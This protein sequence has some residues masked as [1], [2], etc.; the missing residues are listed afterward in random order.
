MRNKLQAGVLVAMGLLLISVP[1]F[2]H[3]GNAAYIKRQVTIQGTVTSWQWVNP[4]SLLKVDV[5][6]GKGGVVNWTCEN[7]APPTLVNYGYT[8][9]TFKPG[10][11]V[12]VVMDYIAKDA[13]IGR[14]AWIKLANGQTLMAR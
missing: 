11:K 9:K 4:H 6:D 13:P 5:P 3:H 14:V 2:A 7:N 12:T 10:D 1:L 8:A